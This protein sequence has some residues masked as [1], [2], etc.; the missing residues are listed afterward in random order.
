[1][2]A[3]VAIVVTI[4]VAA[5]WLA[6]AST[7][8][9]A[10]ASAAATYSTHL[11][12]VVT[13][14]ASATSQGFYILTSDGSVHGYGDALTFGNAHLPH[15]AVSMA[16][17]KTGHG[18][19]VFDANGCAAAFGDATP[20]AQS[21]CNTPL[22]GPVLDAATTPSGLGYWL[23]ANDGGIFAFGD[24]PFLGSMGG[25]HLNAPVV[26]MAP[27]PL[28]K[29]YWEVAGDGGVFAFNVPFLGSMGSTHLNRPVV[30]MVASGVGYMMVASDGGIFNFGNAFYGSLGD[31]PPSTPVIATAPSVQAYGQSNGYWMLDAAGNV[32]GFGSAWMPPTPSIIGGDGT[33]RIAIDIPAGTY[34]TAPITNGCY[35]ARL[36][37]FSGSLSDI[38][39]NDIGNGQRIVTIAPTDAG[40]TTQGC[41]SWSTIVPAAFNPAGP[42]PG[43]GVLRVGVDISPGTWTSTGNSGCY[44]ARLSGFGGSFDEIIANDLGDGT[45]IVSIGSSDV[46]FETSGCTGWTKVG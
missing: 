12:N 19:W 3:K 35:W 33:Y 37:G 31:N 13:I 20:F 36:S 2:R 25:R 26:G 22:N 42:L 7:A 41:G 18:Y 9:P 32:Y 46:G 38:I 44:W 11:P 16:V 43:D 17:T 21:V 28:G 39:E 45:R 14:K 29:G 24:A 5:G 34:L 30:G 4:A 40:F 1:V 8:T 15:R 27:S 23:V 6:I 10:Q